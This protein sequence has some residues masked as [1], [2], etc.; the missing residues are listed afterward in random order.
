MGR[1]LPRAHARARA[2]RSRV[3]KRVCETV[4]HTQRERVGATHYVLRFWHVALRRVLVLLI[5]GDHVDQHVNGAAVARVDPRSHQVV[6]AALFDADR[7]PEIKGVVPRR[8]RRRSADFWE[9]R[10]FWWVAAVHRVRDAYG[11]TAGAPPGCDGALSRVGRVVGQLRRAVGVRLVDGARA[12][13]PPADRVVLRGPLDRSGR[14]VRGVELELR[15]AV[16][17]V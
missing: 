1:V 15:T 14:V 16:G 6:L 4:T 11:W 9:R 2:R 13:V 17:S 5:V 3:H 12:A 10:D 7:A 8:R